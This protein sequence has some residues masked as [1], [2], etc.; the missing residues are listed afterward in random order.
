MSL[1]IVKRTT[2][3]KATRFIRC[4]NGCRSK[5]GG[6]VGVDMGARGA[7]HFAVVLGRYVPLC[8]SCAKAWPGLWDEAL[9]REAEREVV[10]A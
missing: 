8:Q 5:G 4:V 2:R 1:V 6:T 9:E 3:D 10:P 7:S